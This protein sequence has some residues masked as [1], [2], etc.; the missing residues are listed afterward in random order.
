MVVVLCNCRVPDT[1][2]SNHFGTSVL[3]PKYNDQFGI[4]AEVS[5]DNS[6]SVPI[7]L[8]TLRY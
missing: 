6:A 7:C 3:G 5:L 4:S 2:V 1:S 8:R